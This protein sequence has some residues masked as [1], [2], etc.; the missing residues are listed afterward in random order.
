MGSLFNLDSPLMQ[1]LN[2]VTDLII[3]NLVCIFCCL[4]IV[5][6]GASLTAL[7][8]ITLKMVKGEEGYIVRSFFRSFRNN[9]RQA[10][11]IWLIF[12]GISVLYVIDIRILGGMADK[13]PSVLKTIISCFYLFICLTAMYVFPLL[14]RFENTIRNSIRN[15]FFMS[16]LHI[17]KS[18][19]IAVI[20]ILPLIVVQLH[21]M[22]IPVYLL[23][24][25]SGPAFLGSYFWK[26]IF[27][28]YEPEE[29]GDDEENRQIV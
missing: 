26:G 16:I 13:L 2:R 5:T 1:F 17:G 10:T 23:I 19:L 3:L 15:A 7:H 14:A 29:K 9:F 21:F 6:A 20:Y 28:K 18:L 24:G 12:L 22:M 11:L 25:L 8:Y 4:P 27:Q